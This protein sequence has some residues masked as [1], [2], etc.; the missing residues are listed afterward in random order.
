MS[1][2]PLQA[3]AATIVIFGASGDLTQ[4]KLVPALHS[5][6][7]AGY[8]SHQTHVI[9]V[10]RSPHT[11]ASFRDRL[12]QGVTEYARLT[13][14]VCERWPSFAERIGYLS[15]PY[16][17]PETYR[18][19][20]RRLNDLPAEARGRCLFYLATPPIL[21]ETII[22]HLG[23][24][25][26]ASLPRWARIVVE[27]PFGRD[28]TS[29]QNLSRLLH[30]V[31]SEEQVLRIDHYLGKETVQ[32]L[33][34]FRF[35]NA[36]FEPIWNRNYVDH[37]Q[38]TVAEAVGVEH[39]A[40]YYD[41]A[42]ILRDMFQ[43]HLLQLLA[44]TAM[45]PPSRFEAKALRDEKT[46]VLRAVRPDIPH[47]LGQYDGYR[48]EP[49]VSAESVSPT[50]AA[51]RLQID[52]WRWRDVPFYLRSGK[53]MPNRISEIGIHFRHVPHSMFDA[54]DAAPIAP[55]I[56]SFRIQPEEGIHLRFGAKEPGAGM[57]SRPVDMSFCYGEHFGSAALPEA[58][59]RL[60]LDALQGDASL[61]SR[62]DEIELAWS[63]IDPIIAEGR[64]SGDATLETYPPGS[65]GPPSADRLIAQDD[66]AWHNH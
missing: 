34:T 7:C 5:L 65:W 39:R 18:A 43:N 38:I 17:A 62:S 46:K 28:L 60:L 23:A 48:Q 49:G 40:G 53:R 2:R 37:V 14:G 56:L 15:G 22:A 47:A 33:L 24:A 25:G 9:G 64:T 1:D 20:A 66:R 11:D 63:L 57:R 61:F 26:L 59:E 51:L 4:R 54:T 55:N 12:Y 10:A 50:Y 42:G 3:P 36:V 58:Y 52:N 6:A 32:N 19:L 45:E 27:K 29:A 35:A 30:Q 31:F 8:L 13:P 44:L 21:Y 41:R 16:D